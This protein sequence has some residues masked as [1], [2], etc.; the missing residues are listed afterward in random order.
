MRITKR[1]TAAQARRAYQKQWR[2]QNKDKVREYN[3]RYWGRVAER[4]GRK[5]QRED[6]QQD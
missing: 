4:N 1:Q 6:E 3:R 2:A 5:S